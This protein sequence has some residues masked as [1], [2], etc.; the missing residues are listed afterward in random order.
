[1]K[2]ENDQIALQGIEFWSTVCDEEADLA[3]EAMEVH[4]TF[5]YCIYS[6]YGLCHVR[7]WN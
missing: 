4:L 3:I 6:L 5:V 7:L 1:M 2:D